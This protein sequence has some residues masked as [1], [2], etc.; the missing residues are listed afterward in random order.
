M[1]VPEH[2]VSGSLTRIGQGLAEVALWGFAS[3]SGVTQLAI[4]GTGRFRGVTLA[5]E[6]CGCELKFYGIEYGGGLGTQ[7][8]ASGVCTQVK[9]ALGARVQ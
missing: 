7:S 4:A 9:H 3:H 2:L 8:V 6:E 1:Y 5:Q